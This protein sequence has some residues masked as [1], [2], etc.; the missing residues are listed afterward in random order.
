MGT[1]GD[2]PYHCQICPEAIY[3][4]QALAGGT[5][6]A[7]QLW[8]VEE[9]KVRVWVGGS[10]WNGWLRVRKGKHYLVTE[11]QKSARDSLVLLL[12][13]FSRSVLC[14]VAHD[15]LRPMDYSLPGCSVH[16]ISQERVAISFSRGSF[17]PRDW[18]YIS[19]IGRQIYYRWVT[20]ETCRQLSPRPCGPRKEDWIIP[21]AQ[22]QQASVLP[23][24]R[25][26]FFWSLHPRFPATQ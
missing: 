4:P 12:F 8:W 22:S 24:V 15:S 18:T 2:E 23:P 14:W 11:L 6:T 9:M 16:G 26:Q 5:W 7:R 10:S 20:R 3:R 21:K 13:L 25:I 1:R 17:Q 19:C